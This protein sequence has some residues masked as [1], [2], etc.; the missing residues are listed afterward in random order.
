MSWG[1]PAVLSCHVPTP[2]LWLMIKLAYLDK[3]H[4]A[5]VLLLLLVLQTG[6]GRSETAPDGLFSDAAAD[7][8]VLAV[9]TCGLALLLSSLDPWLAILNLRTTIGTWW[10][11]KEKRG[12]QNK[13]RYFL[14]PDT[15]SWTTTHSQLFEWRFVV[16]P[17]N[18]SVKKCALTMQTIFSFSPPSCVL[19]ILFPWSETNVA[20]EWRHNNKKTKQMP[21]F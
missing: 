18:T 5:N 12:V 13:T 17:N 6:L 10:K 11:K 14:S 2:W 19:L 21:H 16:N 9:T 20:C 1:S 7:D 8:D 3:G 15:N 4:R